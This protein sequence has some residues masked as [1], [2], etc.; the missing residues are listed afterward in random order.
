MKRILLAAIVA[1]PLL[2][3]AAPA[4][5]DV[6][7]PALVKIMEVTSM[8]LVK[9]AKTTVQAEGQV[10]SGG[11]TDVQLVV[12]TEKKNGPGVFN[13]DFVGRKPEGMATMALVPVKATFDL[14][15]AAG[16][17]SVVVH[18]AGNSKS[19]DVK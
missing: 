4:A 19:A 17:K 18:A 8:K 12:S 5:E 13:L 1:L 3:A 7:K 11:W 16:V 14:G 6:P 10:N 15:E 2:L 9:G